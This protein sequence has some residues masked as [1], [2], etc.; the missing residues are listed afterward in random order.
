MVESVE[1]TLV[2]RE[3]TRNQHS[4]DDTYF[5]IANRPLQGFQQSKLD[6]WDVTTTKGVFFCDSC[7]EEMKRKFQDPSEEKEKTGKKA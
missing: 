6:T 5:I 4:F 3:F 1:S 7:Q 2:Q